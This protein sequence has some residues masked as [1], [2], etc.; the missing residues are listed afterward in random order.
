MNIAF[1]TRIKRNALVNGGGSV[2]AN[3]IEKGLILKGHK[4]YSNISGTD[5][6][7]NTFT[8]DNIKDVAKEINAFYIRIDSSPERDK[9]TLFRQFNPEAVCIWEINSPL[10]EL[11]TKDISEQKIKQFNTQRKI[12]ARF[13]DAAICVS[14][15]MEH[16]AKFDLGINR[17]YVLPNGSD[18]QVF[19]PEKRDVNLYNSHYFNIIWTGSVE[20]PWQGIN[21]VKILA[22]KFL[23]I[24]NNIR[25]IVTSSGV[26]SNNIVYVGRIPYTEIP[27]YIASADVG[28]CIYEDINFYDKFYFSPL[29]LY[30]YMSCSLPVIGSNVGQIKYIIENYKNGL[31]VNNSIDDIINKILYLKNNRDIGNKM[32]ERGRQ[33]IIS[34]YNWDNIVNNTERIMFD[35]YDEVKSHGNYRRLK[36]SVARNVLRFKNLLFSI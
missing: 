17:A 13:V 32:G 23:K 36:Y 8:K 11:R 6:T 25:F 30:D 20:Y 29:K 3:Q 16:Y 4:L 28:L 33:A 21:I 14:N 10:E 31:L 12:L 1:L 5:N 22:D 9:Q 18:Y 19:H 7:Y 35:V 26:S 27:R 24:D 15:E 2:H 34:R